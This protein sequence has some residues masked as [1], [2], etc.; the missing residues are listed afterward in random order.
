MALSSTN[1]NV[2]VNLVNGT[3]IIEDV[4]DYAAQSVDP[5]NITGIVEISGPTG[6]LFYT[7][8]NPPDIDLS[9]NAQSGPIAIEML[10]NGDYEQGLYTFTYTATDSSNPG[11]PVSL[12]KTF[13]LCHKSPEAVI[14]VEADCVLPLLSSTDSTDYTVGGITPSSITRSHAL[15]F[16]VG[17]NTDPY[18]ATTQK[19]TSDTFYTG[20]Q[21]ITITTDLIYDYPDGFYVID[22][23]EGRKEINVKCDNT[24]CDLYCCLIAMYD[25]FRDAQG[26]NRTL[27]KEL[28]EK[29]LRAE[30]LRNRIYDSY[31]CNKSEDVSRLVEEILKLGNCQPG[32]GCSDD[33]K[34][35]L[36]TAIGSTAADP[37]VNITTFTG[38]TSSATATASNV[39]GGVPNSARVF[40]QKVA[41][42]LQF[43]SVV[44]GGNILVTED[45]DN[46]VI[47][48]NI[49]STGGAS[50]STVVEAGASV[51]ITTTV[52]GNIT[53]YTVAVEQALLDKIDSLYNTEVEAGDGIEV[54]SAVVGDT[55]TFTVSNT[56]PGAEYYYALLRMDLTPASGGDYT[57]VINKEQE[58]FVGDW[59]VDIDFM[60]EVNSVW[61]A[62]NLIDNELKF[63]LRVTPNNPN[64]ENPMGMA[65]GAGAYQ[66][67][68]TV[69]GFTPPRYQ[70]LNFSISSIKP[71]TYYNTLDFDQVTG[72]IDNFY[73]A[74]KSGLKELYP[75][76]AAKYSIF[77]T[78]KI[79]A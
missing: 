41:D 62:V 7:P 6:E 57:G 67:Q 42:D 8:P 35:T 15:N 64:L 71:E 43:R 29:W 52:S 45:G 72:T 16:P 17:T 77:F 28:E 2:D 32:C 25:R 13:E 9:V 55:K 36:I 19:L 76:D 63:R 59:N 66:F 50:G 1:F 61:T 78:I 68:P 39:G 44:G 22:R 75:N 40:S 4:T 51:E 49:S 31:R 65:N 54:T 23:V 69:A 38:G 10:A 21:T 33:S 18:T 46:I 79:E 11:S 47:S 24:I 20:T 53:T 26:N 27:A 70:D 58:F 3:F 30:G 48:A 12:T 74:F 56:R 73:I 37:T 14:E 60:Q 34:P 5:N